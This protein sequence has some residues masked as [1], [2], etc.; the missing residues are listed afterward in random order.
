MMTKS[1]RQY[2]G[3]LE[4]QSRAAERIRSAAPEMLKALKAIAALN[5]WDLG[6]PADP[7]LPAKGA[8]A[9]AAVHAVIAKAE[10]RE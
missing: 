5:S 10:G 9:F 4:E 2:V 7:N 6:L 8:G 3:K 1:T